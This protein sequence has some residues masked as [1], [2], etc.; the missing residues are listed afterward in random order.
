MKNLQH[1]LK[2]VYPVSSKGHISLAESMISFMASLQNGI[3][4]FSQFTVVKLEDLLEEKDME[5]EDEL[6][7][8]DYILID[9]FSGQIVGISRGMTENYNLSQKN[10][11]GQR[12]DQQLS[13]FAII[14]DLASRKK[15]EGAKSRF[16]DMT[17]DL[18][19]FPEHLSRDGDPDNDY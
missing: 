9:Q 5:G 3:T 10:L 6:E 14:K 4:I 15:M 2:L 11:G 19:E 18:T 16:V 1:K 13:V 12:G 8:I 17:L 7:Q